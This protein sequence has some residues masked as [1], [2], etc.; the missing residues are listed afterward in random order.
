MFPILDK[1]MKKFFLMILCIQS[2][3]FSVQKGEKQHNLSENRRQN[4]N[5]T[6]DALNDAIKQNIQVFVNYYI[7]EKNTDLINKQK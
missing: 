6:K 1:K 3:V 7:E 4:I 5:A 2:A